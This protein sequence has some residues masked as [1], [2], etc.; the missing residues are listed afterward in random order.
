MYGDGSI[1]MFDEWNKPICDPAGNP[2]AD[3]ELSEW[4]NYGLG[5]PEN[6]FYW[7]VHVTGASL[8]WFRVKGQTGVD[9]HLRI[10]LAD[11]L[12]CLLGRLKPAHTEIIFD[13]SNLGSRATRWRAHRNEEANGIRTTVWRIGSERL[14]HNGNPSTGTMG[15][16]PPAASIENPQREVVNTI[17]DAG[18]TPTDAD[19]S[20]LAKAIQS[21]QLNYKH[22]TGTANAY[23]A[24]LTPNPGSYFEGLGVILKILN[25][26]TGASVL[27]LNSLGNKPIVRSDGLTALAKAT[28]LP[29]RSFIFCTTERIFASSGT[30]RGN[31]RNADLSTCSARLLQQRHDRLR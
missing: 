22:D 8:I 27:N 13:Y 24:L 9:P 4:P 29:G 25:S 3:G 12:E 7:T 28:C 14:V 6:R 21:G 15:S 17:I 30:K 1:P 20:Q 2:V 31:D 26:N 11:D 10:G 19:L 23:A 5:P 18:L 16:I